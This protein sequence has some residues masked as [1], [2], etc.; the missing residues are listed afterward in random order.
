MYLDI[1]HP[2]IEKA[3]SSHAPSVARWKHALV[4]GLSPPTPPSVK[5]KPKNPEIVWPPMTYEEQ[6]TQSQWKLTNF[7]SKPIPERIEGAVNVTVWNEKIDEL[8]L[9]GEEQGLINI[10]K[11]I[12]LQLSNGAS[13]SVGSPG[14]AHTHV[15]NSFSDPL[16]Q[17]PRV[18]DALASWIK[19][20]H[21]A[22]PLFDI[23]VGKYKYNSLMAVKKAG[24]HIRVV[25]NLKAPPGEAFND[26]IPEE[27]LKEWPV[28][29]L[30]PAKFAKK[31]VNAGPNALMACSDMKDAY[32]ML[33]VSLDQRELQAYDFCGATFIELKLIMGDKLACSMFDKFHHTILEAFVRPLANFPPIA[34]GRTVD[35]IPSVVPPN[36]RHALTSFVSSYRACLELLGIEAAADD[37]TCTKA[38]DCSTCGEVLGIRFDTQSFT[39][40]LPS[41][42]LYNL[43]TS[44]REIAA[45]DYKHSLRELEIVMGRLNHVAQLCPPLK[46][47]I[48]EATCLMAEHM[49][50]F[51]NGKGLIN[52]AQRDSHRFMVTPDVRTDLLMVAAVLADTVNHPLPIMDPDPPIPLCSVPV[53]PDASGH[54]GGP[55]SP[56]LGVFFPP[57]DM[58]HAA[59][60][61]LPFPTEFLLKSNGEALVADTTS[62]LEAL[63][64]LLPMV[65]D[66]HRC[67]GKAL[68]FNID[69]IAVVFSFHKRRSKDR[70]AHTLIRAAYLV[71]GALS[72]RLFVSWV[73]RRSDE[74]SKIADDLT[75]SDFRSVLDL[76][77]QAT[78]KTFE[79]F[80][81]P[82]S[83]WMR[84]P[85]HDRDLGHAIIA[86]MASYYSNLL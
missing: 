49:G 21:V 1:I 17:L 56:A 63:G 52:D 66:P 68:H 3:S 31:I 24:D 50:A 29:M 60:Y 72:S 53:F 28:T 14:N 18:A 35:D 47:Y 55:T 10:M 37:P 20:G 30:T 74:S 79:S 65:I 25:G 44:I 76:F 7:P 4:T 9:S 61:S 46:T 85:V 15:R 71:A 54:I 43:V 39:W 64:I 22:G 27:R 81:P 80:P 8:V 78:K 16:K 77:P 67:V 40:S 19:A 38:F 75:H 13:S 48:S 6:L 34:Q 82:I 26:G 23:E 11:D 45:D 12:G 83:K 51:S 70:L 69:N 5:W 73:P 62:T 59:A 42:K 41:D 84:D 57:F 33:P 32:K 58:N 36:A 86:W 2:L